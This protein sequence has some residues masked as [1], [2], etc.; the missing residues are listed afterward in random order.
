MNDVKFPRTV[1]LTRVK[2][3]VVAKSRHPRGLEPPFSLKYIESLLEGVP[4]LDIRLSDGMA[5]DFSMQDMVR[6]TVAWRPDI[7]VVSAHCLNFDSARRYAGLIKKEYRPVI[8]LIGH[9]MALSGSEENPFDLELPG[10]AEV[11]AAEVIRKLNEGVPVG[12]VKDEYRH[13]AFPLTVQDLDALPFPRFTPG[14]LRVYRSVFPVRMR[15]KVHY[16]FLLSSRGCPHRCVFCSQ[17]IR[18]SWG[19]TVRLRSADGIVD[20]IEHLV[21]SGANVINFADD[22]FTGVRSHV[23]AVCDRIRARGL[24]IPWIAHARVD[25]LDRPL[26]ELMKHS[27]CILLRIGIE[28]GSARIVKR[29]GK[30][31]SPESWGRRVQQTFVHLRENGIATDA[32][33]IIGSPGETE[34]DV[35]ES[36]RLAR[37]IRPDMVQIHFFTP[38]PDTLFSR[39]ESGRTRPHPDMYHYDRPV[40]QMGA[41]APGRLEALRRSFYRRV[42]LR[43]GFLFRHLKNYFSF[44]IFNFGIFLLLCRNTMFAFGREGIVPDTRRRGAHGA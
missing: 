20:E 16:G 23:T 6:R 24:R 31:D 22:N 38:Y 15:R 18:V 40:L 19:G 10:E 43:P 12:T 13:S 11:K 27:G 2:P 25:E 21:G 28:S 1:L 41:I 30:T 37:D 9:Q 44:Y 29:L 17:A 39:Q 7:V 26:I 8:I 33:F 34:N 3:E 5:C 36:M 35:A 42:F 14:E 32:M 4:R